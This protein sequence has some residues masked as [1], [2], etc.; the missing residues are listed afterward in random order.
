[1]EAD[2][3]L[4]DQVQV[5]GPKLSKLVRAVSITVI[6]DP[7]DI[8]G[9]RV[10]PYIGH[11]LGIKADRNPPAERCPGN[12]QVLESGKQEIVHHL[13]LPGHRLDKFRM[14]IDILDQPGSILAHTEK[15]CLLLGRLD[16]PP[17]V[18]ALA[19]HQLG[20]CEK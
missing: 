19:V 11:M 5:G 10:Q 8:V 9:K 3:V 1:M 15:I 13:V 14:L 16:L 2:N 17:A 18:G 4:S 20:L 7:G 6:T 12:T